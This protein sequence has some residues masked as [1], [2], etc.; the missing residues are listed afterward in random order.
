MTSIPTL[1]LNNHQKIPQLGFG[2]FRVDPEKTAGVVSDALEVGYRHIDTAAAY[3]NE[4]G[5][6]EA[7][8]RSG[9]RREEL[10]VTTKL[11]N[12]QQRNAFDAFDQSLERLGLEYADMYL[13]HW[14]APQRDTYI[15]AWKALEMIVGTGRVG[16]IG[17]C[18]FTALQ[19]DRVQK[20]TQVTPVA[21]QIELHVDFQQ[22]QLRTYNTEY[23]IATEAW[24]PLGQ[25]RINDSPELA[26]IAAEHGKSVPQTILRWHMQV[27]NIAIPKSIHRDRM[28]EN[29][30]IF[31]FELTDRQMAEIAGLDKG[32]VARI[33]SRPDE[34]N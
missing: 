25:G 17:V 5:V 22:T 6:G 28:A 27:G 26:G 34:V 2:V 32:S 3:H 23:D 10:F 9:I 15:A 8:E 16:S 30:D 29:L 20:E 11:W 12:D 33:G 21:N 19:L 4:Q 31:D 13:I 1:T 14:P 18:N 7:I 24:A